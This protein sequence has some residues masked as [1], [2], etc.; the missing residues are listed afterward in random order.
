[1][2]L[3]SKLIPVLR[4]GVTVVKMILYKELKPYLTSKYPDRDAAMLAGAV[5]NDIFGTPNP[6]ARFLRFVADNRF[7]I[8]TEI[9][10][11]ASRFDSLRLPLTDALRVQF[12]CD[13]QEGMGNEGILTRARE[14]NILM[15]D[16]D[17]PLP[18]FFMNLVRRLG[19]AYRILAPQANTPPGED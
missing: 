19:V 13:S 1:M 16:R 7:I 8:Q 3:E 17:V 4:E 14:A 11:F 10:G 18:K 2:E 5:I 9:D 12:L 15:V 6:E